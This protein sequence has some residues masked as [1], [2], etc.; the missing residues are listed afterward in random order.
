MLDQRLLAEATAS[1]IAHRMLGSMLIV[2]LLHRITEHDPAA[3]RDLFASNPEAALAAAMAEAAQ[4][5]DDERQQMAGD[6]PARIG[7]YTAAAWMSLNEALMI[8]DMPIDIVDTITPDMVALFAAALLA[9]DVRA[10]MVDSD[11]EAA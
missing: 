3:G 5:T 9:R 1:P 10:S 8:L 2:K 4:L 6:F 7:E 11:E